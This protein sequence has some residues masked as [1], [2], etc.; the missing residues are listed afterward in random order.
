MAVVV[1]E[2]VEAYLNTGGGAGDDQATQLTKL[3]A[4]IRSPECWP[5]IHHALQSQITATVAQ[6]PPPS[7]PPYT[8]PPPSGPTWTYQRPA[9]LPSR[10]PPPPAPPTDEEPPF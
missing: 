2:A 6:Q 7:S 1:R 8:P 3:L 5:Q 4:L 9:D 10:S